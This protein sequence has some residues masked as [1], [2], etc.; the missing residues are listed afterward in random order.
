MD[1]AN[2]PRADSG[3]DHRYADLQLSLLEE[4]GTR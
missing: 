4:R 1:P 3:S 2:Y